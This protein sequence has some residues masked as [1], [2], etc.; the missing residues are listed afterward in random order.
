MCKRI[1]GYNVCVNFINILHAI[2]LYERRFGSFFYVHVTRE[3]LPKLRSYEKFARKTLM[4]LTT[5]HMLLR[6]IYV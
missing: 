2:F 3:K 6:P 5:E 1:I 4:K